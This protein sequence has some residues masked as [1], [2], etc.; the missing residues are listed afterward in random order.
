[1][2]HVCYLSAAVRKDDVPVLPHICYARRYTLAALP[3]ICFR[4]ATTAASAP[5][6]TATQHPVVEHKGN[7]GH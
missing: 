4:Y 3:Q 1:M 2:L 7:A 5:V 6:H